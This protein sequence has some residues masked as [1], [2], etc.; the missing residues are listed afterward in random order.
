MLSWTGERSIEQKCPFWRAALKTRKRRL[1]TSLDPY[2]THHPFFL[3]NT[4]LHGAVACAKYAVDG[5]V[6]ALVPS[7]NTSSF[8]AVFTK[9][10]SNVS[11]SVW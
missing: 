8:P 2:A 7:S 5:T 6:N 1:H 9:S 4:Y 11:R 3:S 10:A